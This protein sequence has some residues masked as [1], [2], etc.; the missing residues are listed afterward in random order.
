M[1]CTCLFTG[2]IIFLIFEI[3]VLVLHISLNLRPSRKLGKLYYITVV[4]PAF[5][6]GGASI[7][8][9]AWTPD[10]GAFWQKCMQKQRIG[11]HRGVCVRHTP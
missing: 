10:V 2:K 8:W 4:D 3:E 9:G 6:V 7:R 1:G 5:P 11:S